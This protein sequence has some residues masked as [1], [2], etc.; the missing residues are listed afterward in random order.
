MT[1]CRASNLF[2]LAIRL[3]C[4]AVFSSP[5]SHTS[6]A[7]DAPADK[8]ES[9]ADWKPV[10][11]A[12][13]AAGELKDHV[14]TITI[15]RTDLDVEIEGMLIPAGAGLAHRFHFFICPC[16]KTILVGE[17]CVPEYEAN[18]VIDALRAGAILR[19][20]SA[21]NLFVGD[22]PKMMAVRFQG[23]GDG[24]QMAKLLKE[25]LRWTGEARNRKAPAP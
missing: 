4:L 20:G 9:A 8:H 22:R 2:S 14:Y 12:V 17:F 11:D 24:V 6:F 7:A 5:F 19:V 3:I 10:A 13:G 1:S 21:S 23:E 16:G 25:A 15:P 18:D